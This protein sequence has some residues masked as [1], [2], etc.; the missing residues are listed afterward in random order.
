MG[1]EPREGE[2]VPIWIRTG[3]GV[4]LDSGASSSFNQSHPGGHR[5]LIHFVV[6]VVRVAVGFVPVDVLW[7]WVWLLVLKASAALTPS[8]VTTGKKN[9]E[10]CQESSQEMNETNLQVGLLT[11]RQSFLVQPHK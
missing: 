2:R 5:A 4:Q 8:S 9:A 3:A 11:K 7:L 6:V 10:S 1:L